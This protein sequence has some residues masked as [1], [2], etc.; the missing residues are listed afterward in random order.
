M[1]TCV[2]DIINSIN[3]LKENY[4]PKD[5]KTVPN[6]KKIH[7]D[8]MGFLEDGKNL[9]E[10]MWITKKGRLATLKILTEM[11]ILGLV[12]QENGKGYVNNMEYLQEIQIEK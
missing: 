2:D 6:V 3:I 9:D 5:K 8:I 4:L 7:K 1:V 10:I 12:K 11:E